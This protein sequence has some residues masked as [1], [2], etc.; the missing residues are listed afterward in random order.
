MKRLLGAIILLHF[1]GAAAFAQSEADLKL[2]FEGR[3]V[4]VLIDMPASKDGVDVYPERTQPLDFSDYAHR[5][6]QY[7]IALEEGDRAMITRIRIKEKHIEFQLGGGGYGTFGDE[8]S[9]SVAV[10]SVSKSKREKQLE[11][12][13]KQEPN[14]IRRKKM[15][16]EVDDLRRDRQ[17]EERRLEAERATA[18]ELGKQRIEQRR[19]QG[20]SRFNIH[21]ETAL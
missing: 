6:K 2:H 13:I 10:E 16:E 1:A 3:K 9:P 15:K 8:T 21:F 19:L 11:D 4:K 17:R 18:V 20:G 5:I 12:D 7:G 14:E